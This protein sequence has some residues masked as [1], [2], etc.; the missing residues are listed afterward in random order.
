MQAASKKALRIIA[1]LIMTDCML[2]DMNLSKGD[3]VFILLRFFTLTGLEVIHDSHA[4]LL[5]R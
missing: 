5:K 4:V 1:N 2:S 3:F